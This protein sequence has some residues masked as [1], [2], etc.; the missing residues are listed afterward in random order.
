MI[1]KATLDKLA[2]GITI[3]T[4]MLFAA[5]IVLQRVLFT[6]GGHVTAIMVTLLLLSIYLGIYLFRPTAYEIR[7]QQVIIHRPLRNKILERVN[8]SKAELLGPSALRHTIRTF[9]NG[10]LFGYYGKFSNA[11]IGNMTWYATNRANAVLLEMTGGDKIVITPDNAE[12]FLNAL[13][14][15]D[16]LSE[17][18]D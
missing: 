13:S 9:G 6:D 1:F 2:K 4:T 18:F 7:S 17:N 11:K 3:G 12:A 10:G 8:I 5:I 14:S 15:P 16:R